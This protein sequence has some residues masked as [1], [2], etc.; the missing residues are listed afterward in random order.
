MAVAIVFRVSRTD[1]D[2]H[3]NS[4]QKPNVTDLR[5]ISLICISVFQNKLLD[6]VEQAEM[7]EEANGTNFIHKEFNHDNKFI[8]IDQTGAV[9]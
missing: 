5:T 7:H 9:I 1:G 8:H 6:K 4:K 3:F 2:V